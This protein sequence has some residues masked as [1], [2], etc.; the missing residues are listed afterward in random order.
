MVFTMDSKPLG[1]MWIREDHLTSNAIRD[2]AT[3]RC[4]RR[5]LRTI[6]AVSEGVT[7]RSS[8]AASRRL[9]DTE[10]ISGSAGTVQED[11]MACAVKVHAGH[12]VFIRPWLS[13]A[14]SHF[15]V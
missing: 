4:H 5:P 13:E 2:S 3:L 1:A 6:A 12:S 7:R 8:I 9:R 11:Q 14:L 15:P 10:V